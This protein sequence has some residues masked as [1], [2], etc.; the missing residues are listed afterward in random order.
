MGELAR[1]EHVQ[2]ALAGD[3]DDVP[4]RGGRRQ[5]PC[6]RQPRLRRVQLGGAGVQHHRRARPAAFEALL[7]ARAG[8]LELREHAG[9]VVFVTLVVARHE[10]LGGGVDPGHVGPTLATWMRELCR[11]FCVQSNWRTRHPATA[12]CGARS[13]R[14]TCDAFARVVNPLLEP[15]RVVE[16]RLEPARS[17]LGLA[18]YG[19][20][21]LV[22]E[23][24]LGRL[25]MCA[26]DDCTAVFADTSSQGS[27]RYCTRT[28][29]TRQN[30]RR[31][32]RAK[33]SHALSQQPCFV[34]V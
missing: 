1:A 10:R 6:D 27:R 32:R 12:S 20:A 17:D 7:E 23:H 18:A 16:G 21:S 5:P 28:C 15:P 8:E 2:L 30:V 9:R 19:L 24:G 4:A 13:W 33:P 22:A 3:A 31:H 11:V 26:A 14:R 25:G 34:R 29:S